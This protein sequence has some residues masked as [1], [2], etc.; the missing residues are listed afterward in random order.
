MEVAPDLAVAEL[1]RL[2]PDRAVRSYPAMLS[3]EADATAW[4]R[5]GAP[6]GA[7]VVADYQAAPRG[8]GGLP[9]QVRQGVG[10]GFSLVLRPALPAAREGWL[11]TVGTVAL[12]DV[13]DGVLGEATVEWPDEVVVG[14]AH[15][16]SVGVATDTDATGVR[17]AVLNVR[18]DDVAPPRGRV[19][20]RIV[21][22]VERRLG[23]EPEQ[24]LVEHRRRCTTIGRAVRASLVPMGASGVEIEGAAV[25][26]L[27]DGAL[28]VRTPAGRR[29]AVLPH[30][31]GR[32]DDLGTTEGEGA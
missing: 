10:L 15:V 1:E 21:D 4:A 24:V 12:G 5:S 13:A 3:T 28:L 23:E 17:W 2:L 16:A 22:A 7:V 6:S 32:L 8:R 27:A 9:W 18:L 30:H 25:D 29:V 26:V 20:A 19:L 11:Y 31:L 14:G